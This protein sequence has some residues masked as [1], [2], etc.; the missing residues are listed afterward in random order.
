MI[1]VNSDWYKGVSFC[2]DTIL[3]CKHEVFIDFLP[4]PAGTAQEEINAASG[5]SIYGPAKEIAFDIIEETREILNNLFCPEKPGKWLEQFFGGVGTE[6]D[7]RLLDRYA[8]L[9]RRAF[10][11]STRL[12]TLGSPQILGNPNQFLYHVHQSLC[13]QIEHARLEITDNNE[14]FDCS[15]ADLNNQKT[16]LES[17]LSA[18]ENTIDPALCLW[19]GR[20]AKDL[21]I[22]A[23]KCT[24]LRVMEREALGISYGEVFGASSRLIHY[25]A[26]SKLDHGK[27]VL[28]IQDGLDRAVLLALCLLFRILESWESSGQVKPRELVAL[29]NLVN[30]FVPGSLA[31]ATAG[32]AKQNDVVFYSGQ[33]KVSFGRVISHNFGRKNSDWKGNAYRIKDFQTGNDD[34]YPSRDVRLLIPTAEE[35]DFISAIRHYDSSVSDIAGA[36]EHARTNIMCHAELAQ[37]FENHDPVVSLFVQIGQKA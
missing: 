7:E 13:S 14:F 9:Q 20:S 5:R 32:A 25:E 30:S 31:N 24:H 1:S 22:A 8:L 12:I 34:W 4:Y 37:R 10:E 18:I 2:V 19:K 26:I 3:R 27:L 36:L 35:K 29:E 16:K 17:Y 23:L 11:K 6:I 28:A 33:S 21:Y 15:N